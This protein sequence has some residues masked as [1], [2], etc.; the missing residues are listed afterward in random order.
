MSETPTILDL[1]D[2]ALPDP[3]SLAPETWGW[4][5][6]A[7]AFL[8][9]AVAAA[10]LALRRRGRN[11]YRREALSALARLTEGAAIAALVKRVGIVAYGRRAVAPLSGEA[12]LRFLDATID[13]PLFTQGPGA[14]LGAHYRGETA[15][16]EALRVLVRQWIRRHRARP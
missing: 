2:V 1:R 12:W 3:V 13:D 9:V 16:V 15:D 7:L 11:R 5:V 4:A 8:A 6:L 10:L 14:A